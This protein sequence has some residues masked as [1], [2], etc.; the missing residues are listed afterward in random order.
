MLHTELG[1]SEP[2]PIRGSPFTVTVTDPWVRHR[3]S[4]VAPSKRKGATLV[5]VAGELVGSFVNLCMLL[6]Q[7]H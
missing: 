2:I 6:P 7:L 1:T 4:G 3:V 5:A